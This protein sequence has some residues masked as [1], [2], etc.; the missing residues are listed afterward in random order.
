MIEN[1]Q[2]ILPILVNLHY[3]LNWN[4]W[5]GRSKDFTRSPRI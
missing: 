2:E 1:L 3:G 4:C 5:I